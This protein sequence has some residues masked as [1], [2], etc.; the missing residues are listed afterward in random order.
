MKLHH[1]GIVT[2]D[3]PKC[4]KVYEALGYTDVKIVDDPIQMASIALMQRE[5]EPLIELIAPAGEQSPAWKWLERIT[6]GAYH[7]CYE[8]PSLDEAIPFMKERGFSVIM[9]PVPAIAFENRRVT[10]LWSTLTGLVELVE[11]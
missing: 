9:K 4:M 11:G 6:A 7:I 5:G 10:F 1:V 8:A 3:L 2:K